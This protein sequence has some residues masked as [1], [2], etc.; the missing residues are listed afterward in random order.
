M[1][2][3]QSYEVSAHGA[4]NGRARSAR[5]GTG[6]RSPECC[7]SGHA[8]QF[9]CAG[10]LAK[11]SGAAPTLANHSLHATG[12]VLLVARAVGWL[13]S[14]VSAGWRAGLHEGLVHGRDRQACCGTTPSCIRARR[15]PR[16]TGCCT[17]AAQDP[18]F[19]ST[20]G[21]GH[22]R[23]WD[24][25]PRSAPPVRWSGWTASQLSPDFCM[26]HGAVPK[27]SPWGG[28]PRGLLRRKKW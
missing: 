9:R 11:Q 28:A 10:A 24:R 7:A 25:R 6:L 15:A 16:L 2:L 13:W 4:N 12:D 20:G 14:R 3:C 5:W 26:E 18:T 19:S 8:V 21:R 22:F 23:P 1:V 27:C 17:R